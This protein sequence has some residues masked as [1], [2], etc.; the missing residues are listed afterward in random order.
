MNTSMKAITC[1]EKL[2]FLLFWGLI[3]NLNLA[4]SRTAEMDKGSFRET[5][6]A[7]F[8]SSILFVFM[9][10]DDGRVCLLG[11]FSFFFNL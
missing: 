7:L 1:E 6:K 4:V 10:D 5:K 3:L 8:N 9:I 2:L 11:K